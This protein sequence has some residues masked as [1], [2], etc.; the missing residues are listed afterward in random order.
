MSVNKVIL[1]GRLGQ[2]PD[3]K[4]LEGGKFVCNMSL[5]TSKKWKDKND[6]WQEKT[7]W[8]R[9]VAWGRTAEN[10]AKYLNKGSQVYVEGELNNETY[11]KDGEKRYATKVTASNVTFLTNSS[12]KD[13]AETDGPGF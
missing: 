1:V 2:D 8:H 5:A 6:Q 12:S 7:D 10:C 13:S 3:L 9:V 4:A 11:E